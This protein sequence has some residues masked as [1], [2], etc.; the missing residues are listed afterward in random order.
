M[1]TYVNKCY[2]QNNSAVSFLS[3]TGCSCGNE[4]CCV[5]LMSRGIS[6]NWKSVRSRR[7][8][9]QTLL[10][11]GSRRNLPTH[12]RTCACV[13]RPQPHA[14]GPR[15]SPWLPTPGPGTSQCPLPRAFAAERVPIALQEKAEETCIS[16]KGKDREPSAL[17]SFP[18]LQN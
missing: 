2:L 10:A 17:F 7:V 8:G 1:F 13:V 11:G 16:S 15:G 12:H 6:S 18:L 9:V 3:E 4:H 5:V 14:Q